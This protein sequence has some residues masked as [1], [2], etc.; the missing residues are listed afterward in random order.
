[1]ARLVRHQ[2]PPRWHC[3]SVTLA[4][5]AAAFMSA[6]QPASKRILAVILMIAR[7]VPHPLVLRAPLHPRPGRRAPQ[8]E[9]Q[10]PDARGQDLPRRY[11]SPLGAGSPP[12]GSSVT[13]KALT[14]LTPGSGATDRL[15]VPLAST[16]KTPADTGGL[17][18]AIAHS[19]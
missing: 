11:I 13:A 7:T 10:G 5:M 8:P 9:E 18:P 12:A 14:A 2:P 1:M 17:L 19:W 4:F 16:E 3:V 15:P 6:E